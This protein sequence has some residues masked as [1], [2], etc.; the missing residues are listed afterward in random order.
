MRDVSKFGGGGDKI[1]REYYDNASLLG[2]NIIEVLWVSKTGLPIY[3][4]MEI[5]GFK[6]PVMD[7][8]P[9]LDDLVTSAKWIDGTLKFFPD[10]K[11]RC[12]GY[13]FDIPENRQLIKTSLSTN[14]F[15]VVDQN[16]REEILKEAES[17]GIRTVPVPKTEVIIKKTV[18]EEAAEKHAKT[19][20]NKLEEMQAKMREMQKELEIAQ[21]TRNVHVQKRL[22]GTPIPV[23]DEKIEE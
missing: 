6:Y 2:V 5:R 7:D 18:R 22:E 9:V 21:N 13:I 12:W 11:G 1:I 15:K 8:S 10:G 16:V 19:L 4:V 14:W 20:A 23:V 17:E 3:D